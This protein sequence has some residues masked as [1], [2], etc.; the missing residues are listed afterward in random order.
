[1][2]MKSIYNPK[3][4]PPQYFKNLSVLEIKQAALLTKFGNLQA[5]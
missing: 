4:Q 2:Y 5:E 3:L 1:M